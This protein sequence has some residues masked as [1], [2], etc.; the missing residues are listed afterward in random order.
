MSYRVMVQTFSCRPTDW[1]GNAERWGTKEEASV[2]GS[3]LAGRWLSVKE[4]K[5]VES[6][7]DV[8]VRLVKQDDGAYRKEYLS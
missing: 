5:V 2:A 1:S 4:W 6:E 8:T 7:D 3:D